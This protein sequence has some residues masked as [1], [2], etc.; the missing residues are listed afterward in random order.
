[1][2]ALPFSRHTRRYDAHAH[3]PISAHALTY[4]STTYKSPRAATYYRNATIYSTHLYIHWYTLASL[5]TPS[6]LPIFIHMI[7]PLQLMHIT[8]KMYAGR[9]FARWLKT[10]RCA[11]T[12]A[13]CLNNARSSI[14]WNSSLS[15]R[16]YQ[17]E[18]NSP[19]SHFAAHNAV[20]IEIQQHF[21]WLAGFDI[22]LYAFSESARAV[23]AAGWTRTSRPRHA[24]LLAHAFTW[25]TSR[26]QLL[27]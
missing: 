5:T 24:N 3:A 11:S 2:D 20:R 16:F 12:D 10:Y 1:M 21:A 27:S 8:T 26:L 14:L 25:Y 17:R 22:Y 4:F 9:H 19:I 15:F 18:K 23:L 6:G 7:S 13:Y